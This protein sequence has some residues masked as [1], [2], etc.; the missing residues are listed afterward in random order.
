MSIVIP[1][2][3]KGINT[4]CPINKE[5][6]TDDWGD[7]YIVDFQVDEL[8]KL[9]YL[10]NETGSG[11]FHNI[12]YLL[13]CYRD[14]QLLGLAVEETDSMYKR[15]AKADEIFINYTYTLPC[16]FTYISGKIDLI[17]SHSKY[18]SLG[19]ENKIT[20]IMPEGKKIE[21]S[22][23]AQRELNEIGKLLRE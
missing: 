2:N 3:E 6:I 7:F 12:H 9:F 4:K 19:L 22:C 10:L 8:L 17:W 18:K 23:D 5:F 11:Y 20:K 13:E 16:F 14:N 21:C 1:V 15:G